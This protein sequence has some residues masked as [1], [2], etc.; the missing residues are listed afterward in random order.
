MIFSKNMSRLDQVIRFVAGLVLVGIAATFDLGLIVA[1]AVGAFGV[2]NIASAFTAHCPVYKAI[3]ISS[4]PQSEH[5]AGMEDPAQ[6][7]K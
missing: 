5:P 4:R 6:S 7:R 1:V 2:L 3:G